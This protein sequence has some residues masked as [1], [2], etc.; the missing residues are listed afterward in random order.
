MI[1]TSPACNAPQPDDLAACHALIVELASS[2][3]GLTNCREKLAHE[4][5]ELKLT[6]ENLL[7]RLTTT[8]SS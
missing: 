4:N 6:I 5:E 7:H 1:A 8:S 2:V 3:N